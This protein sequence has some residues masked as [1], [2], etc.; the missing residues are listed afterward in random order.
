MEGG[1][2]LTI[3]FPWTLSISQLSGVDIQGEVSGAVSNMLDWLNNSLINPT[4]PQSDEVYD[5][6]SGDFTPIEWPNNFPHR[7]KFESASDLGAAIQDV[8]V[9]DPTEDRTVEWEFINQSGGI[10]MFSFLESVRLQILDKKTTI[11]YGVVESGLNLFNPLVTWSTPITIS[12]AAPYLYGADGLETYEIVPFDFDDFKSHIDIEFS[13]DTDFDLFGDLTI[14]PR[15][16]NVIISNIGQIR[17]IDILATHDYTLV[18]IPIDG[19]LQSVW[20]LGNLAQEGIVSSSGP[21]SIRFSTWP[22]VE[23][24]NLTQQEFVQDVNL[25][26]PPSQESF[27]YQETIYNISEWAPRILLTLSDLFNII[28]FKTGSLHKLGVVYYDE[29][30]RSGFVN[31]IGTAYANWYNNEARLLPEE[32]PAP[33]QFSAFNSENTYAGPVSF[34]IDFPVNA[35][36]SPPSWAK[37]YQIVYPGASSVL[38]FVQ[39]TVGEA[40]V[41]RKGIIEFGAGPTRRVDV[42]SKRIY[43][44]LNTLDKY[45]SEK[46]TFRDY[47]FTVGDKLRVVS[48]KSDF[49]DGTEDATLLE[50]YPS[51]SDGSIVEFDVVGV[52]FLD[53]T[54]ENPI[55]FLKNPDYSDASIASPADISDRHVGKFLVLE[56]PRVV[57]GSVDENG[58][59]IMFGGFDWYDIANDINYGHDNGVA[60]EEIP[61]PDGGIPDSGVH[62]YKDCLVE[63]YTPRPSLHDEFWYEIGETR[64]V[65][66]PTGVGPDG[67]PVFLDYFSHGD[68]F[69]VSSGDI[70]YRPVPCKASSR[71]GTEGLADWAWSIESDDWKYKSRNVEANTVSDIVG[72]PM[73][74]RGRAHIKFE[75]AATYRRFAQVTYSDEWSGESRYLSLSS[76]NATLGNFYDFDKRY[77]AAR[78]IAEYGN[79]GSLLALQENKMSIS[80]VNISIIQD[81]SG[82]QNLALST[83]VLNNTQYYVGDYGC[84]SQPSAV[85]IQDNDVYFVDDSRR[86][87][88]RFSNGQLVPISNK[89]V[90]SQIELAFDQWSSSPETIVGGRKVKKIVSGYDPENDVYYVTFYKPNSRTYSGFINAGLPD[91]YFGG[92]ITDSSTFSYSKDDGWWVSKHSFVPQIY[93]NQNDTMFSCSYVRNDS[94]GKFNNEDLLFFKHGVANPTCVYYL[95]SFDFM[96]EVVSNTSPSVVKTFDAVS[97]EGDD[98]LVT[99]TQGDGDGEASSDQ[100][101]VTQMDCVVSSNLNQQSALIRNFA[102]REGAYYSMVPMDISSNSVSYITPLGVGSS[103]NGTELVFKSKLSGISIPGGISVQALVGQFLVNLGT[104][105]I[106][107]TVVSVD[108][109]NQITLSDEITQDVEDVMIFM[110]G[111]SDIDGDPIRGHY[112]KIKLTKKGATSPFDLYAINAKVTT[113]QYGHGLQE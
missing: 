77:G 105:D 106:P 80:P 6:G 7:I 91:I 23:Q 28:G 2:K 96:V 88:L 78:Y 32:N 38:D 1:E 68:P 16:S 17:E 104:S 82:S 22:S 19:V 89:E 73:W 26:G 98:F 112:A 92:G 45:R 56:C 101:P 93:S 51:A 110:V 57:A 37:T 76:F 47:S 71:I 67:L 29:Y 74:D 62:W 109:L 81:A 20:L 72:E 42:D 12:S 59:Q 36:N 61:Y 34:E 21:N 107:L 60:F 58:N 8:L 27:I 111:R 25:L 69:I 52:E 41:K 14:K 65:V 3:K 90:S 84:G 63:I 50:I 75:G 85:L 94:D 44:S 66:R 86:R 70:H 15:V 18:D 87:V 53:R 43:V 10:S 83:N 55:A 102:Y 9:P 30:N 79:S 64:P 24:Q 95:Q 103:S 99:Q 5:L 54:A 11:K 4:I 113:S 35:Q 108:S 48:W 31:D 100:E 40:F 33:I 49:G 46:N 13:F 39:Y 97:F